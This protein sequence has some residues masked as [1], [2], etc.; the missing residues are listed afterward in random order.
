MLY[1]TYFKNMSNLPDKTIK[2]LVSLFP[3]KEINIDNTN[4]FHVPNLSADKDDFER[5]KKNVISFEK[6][7]ENYM[8]KLENHIH[9]IKI[10]K[11]IVL[12][13]QEGKDIAFICYEKELTKCH[14]YYLAKY[15]E[16]KYNIEWKE[17]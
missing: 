10:I 12:A 17:L 4:V 2:I 16:D 3:P 5:Y 6:Y 11:N 9:S 1:T 7:I 15:I 8:N 14:R 13:L